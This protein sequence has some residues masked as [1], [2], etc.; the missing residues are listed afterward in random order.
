MSTITRQAFVDGCTSEDGRIDSTTLGEN[1]R[2]DLERSGIPGDELRRAFG[3][4][5][6]GRLGHNEGITDHFVTI[7]GRGVDD[8]GHLF[9]DF[10]DPGDGGALHRFYVDENTGQLFKEAAAGR[11]RFAIDY[12]YQL[13]Q[14]RTWATMPVP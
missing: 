11:A 9:Y 8:Q 2:R 5:G 13:T 1:T 7:S 12:A 14:V 3:R 10:R 4:D 6:A